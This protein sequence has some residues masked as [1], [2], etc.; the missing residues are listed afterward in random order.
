VQLRSVGSR[1]FLGIVFAWAS[2][3]SGAT[4]N[5]TYRYDELGR[6]IGTATSGC[7][8]NGLATNI[9][10][11]PAGNRRTYSVAGSSGSGCAGTVL[12]ADASFENP[13]QNGGYTYGPAI[14]G[15]SFSGYAG[16]AG[17]GSG[18]GFAAAPDGSQ[19]AFVQGYASANGTIS[20]AVSGL[21][22]GA[23]YAVRFAV[24]QRPG[25][26]ANPLAV[27]FAP[28]PQGTA[29]LGTFTPTSTSF[30]YVT[31]ASFTASAATGT[32]TF[33]GTSSSGDISTGLDAIS[34]VAAAAPTVANA[35][36]ETPAMGGGYVY[37]P[38]ASGASFTGRAGIA[39]NGSGFGFAA[40]P[41]G[42]Q[43]G[44]L[45]GWSSQ[46]GAIALDVAGLTPGATYRIR[47][48]HAQRPGFAANPVTVSFGGT[49][50]GTYT[51]ASTAFAQVTTAIFTAS[52]A[53][54]TVTF[55]GAA[56]TADTDTAIDAV[57]V[58]PG[59]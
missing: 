37:N 12:V 18:W 7:T 27:G 59:P 38:T 21:T 4:E 49:G 20:L 53:T 32:L 39:G 45:Q 36:F 1:I 15:A 31:S 46:N 14:T 54:G 6:L 35:S 56:S 25:F 55:T 22:P 40:A 10:Y 9:S 33:T 58:V 8:N 57:T 28:T 51:P 16:V 42:T 50:L 3:A 23:S 19:V 47:F 11:D 34:I 30:A 48:S 26:A 17:N 13:P 2:A 5:I 52:A 43:V 44:L 24:A 29:S 41:D